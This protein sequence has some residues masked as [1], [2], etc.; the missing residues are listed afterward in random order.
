MESRARIH[1]QEKPTSQ[2]STEQTLSKA[3]RKGNGY[4]SRM[5]VYRKYFSRGK[6]RTQ[7]RNAVKLN[8]VNGLAKHLKTNMLKQEKASMHFKTGSET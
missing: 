4:E 3:G 7:Y 6:K 2:E 1:K 5:E 8:T